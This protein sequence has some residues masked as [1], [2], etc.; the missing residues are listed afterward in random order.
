MNGDGGLVGG[1]VVDG[2]AGETADGLCIEEN[3]LG[4]DSGPQRQGVV[5]EDPAEDREP[6]VL[7]Q[8]FRVHLSSDSALS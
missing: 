8:R 1:D 5:I 6:T 3:E 2:E 7:V 4:G